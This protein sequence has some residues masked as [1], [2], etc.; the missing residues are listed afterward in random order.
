MRE[1]NFNTEIVRS[2]KALKIWSYKIADSPTSWTMKATRFTPDKPCDIIACVDG[3]FVAIESKQIKKFEAFGM[4]HLRDVQIANLDHVE[5]CGGR[6]F[7]FL[8]IRIKAVKG[9]TKHE[10]RLIIFPWDEFKAL[11]MEGSIGKGALETMDFLQGK[12]VDQKV[13]FDLREWAEWL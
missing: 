4:R 12:T 8:N 10:N 2:L 3:R 5:R 11:C 6:S 9:K 1:S 7:V 13:L